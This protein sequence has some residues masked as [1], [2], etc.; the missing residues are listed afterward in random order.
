MG[1][2]LHPDYQGVFI[3][4]IRNLRILEAAAELD[5]IVT[6]HAGVDIGLPEPVHC[7]PDK[8]REVFKQIPYSKIVLAHTGGWQQW[9]MVEEY[10]VDLPLYFDLSFSLP[11]ISNQQMLRILTAHTP[12]R[13]L[14]AT[15]SPWGN[16]ADTLR[17]L[18]ELPLPEGWLDQLCSGTAK[19][20]LGW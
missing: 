17:R 10:L 14:F 20:L 2:K 8:M 5:L 12:Q 7:P 4:D 13:C 19:T 15:D 16:Q 6:I 18:K 9:D 3:N 11:F 1:I